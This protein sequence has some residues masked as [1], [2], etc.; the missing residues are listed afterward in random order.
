MVAAATSAIAY[1]YNL[2]LH[3]VAIA[4]ALAA[5]GV[6]TAAYIKRAY[7]REIGP[8]VPPSA[9]TGR[10]LAIQQT[11]VM[12]KEQTAAEPAQE[13]QVIFDQMGLPFAGEFT[14]HQR[15]ASYANYYFLTC[16]SHRQHIEPRQRTYPTVETI[17]D[18]AHQLSAAAHGPSYEIVLTSD[19]DLVVRRSTPHRRRSE[20]LAFENPIDEAVG[21]SGRFSLEE[22]IN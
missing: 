10:A 21:S 9:E 12:A 14:I 3:P 1:D 18:L 13:S 15:M 22:S 4:V 8:M 6:G 2:K 5:A 11:K 19:G 17:V 16:Y 20:R 7:D